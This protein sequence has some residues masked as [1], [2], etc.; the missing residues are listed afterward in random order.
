MANPVSVCEWENLV[1]MWGFVELVYWHECAFP[2]G[3]CNS[4]NTGPWHTVETTYMIEVVRVNVYTSTGNMA[5]EST[6]MSSSAVDRA[7]SIR[8]TRHTLKGMCTQC[9]KTIHII[10]KQHEQTHK[11]EQGEKGSSA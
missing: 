5:M 2:S 10:C 6:V 8:T 1:W 11:R 9:C 7:G 3:D 4:T